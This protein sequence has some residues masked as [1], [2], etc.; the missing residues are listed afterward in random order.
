MQLPQPPNTQISE[1]ETFLGGVK[2]EERKEG[3]KGR[4]EEQRMGV[5]ERRRNEKRQENCV[6]L[7]VGID[8][9]SILYFSITKSN[10]ADQ[11]PSSV[12]YTVS[13]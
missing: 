12:M 7:K 5:R 9:T 13:E 6:T 4:R 11:K 2:Q 8:T 1:C 10:S 3:G